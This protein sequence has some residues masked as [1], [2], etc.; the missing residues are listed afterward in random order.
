MP[1]E[2][3]VGAQVKPASSSQLWR[4]LRLDAG[5]GQLSVK[6]RKLHWWLLAA[7]LEGHANLRTRATDFSFRCEWVVVCVCV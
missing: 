3:C 2:G 6:S 5:S 7:D 4:R 1:T